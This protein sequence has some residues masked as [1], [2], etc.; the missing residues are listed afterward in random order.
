MY[1]SYD[2]EDCFRFHKTAEEAKAAA[3]ESLQHARD[4]APDGWG[5][6]VEQICWGEVRGSVV[7]T[8]RRP[9][10]PDDGID[11]D[12]IVDYALQDTANTTMGHQ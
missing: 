11:C 3:E 5:D 4:Y 10:T 1:F 8:M 12:E 6:S 9:A 7:E 2:P